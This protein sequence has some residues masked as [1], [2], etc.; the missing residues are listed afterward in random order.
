MI[1]RLIIGILMAGTLAGTLRLP[2]SV[3]AQD[4]AVPGVTIHVVQRGENLFRIALGYGLTTEELAEFNGITNPGNILVGQ[5]LLIPTGA[6]VP[7]P[8]PVQHTV[9]TGETLGSIANLY[10]KTIEELV[11]LNDITNVNAI[12]VGQV[13]TIT[14]GIEANPTQTPLPQPEQLSTPT[15]FVYIVQPGETMYRIALR[16]NLTVNELAS[17]NSITDPT[18]IDAGQHLIIP[19]VTPPQIAPD[20]PS[21]ITEI[22]LS[23]LILVEGQA[24]RIRLTT[25]TA[26]TVSGTLLNNPLPFISEEGN[27][28]HIA[29][30]GIPL[31]TANG[32]Y[33]L[34][35][36]LTQNNGQQTNFSFNVQIV[37]G[38]YGSQNISLPEGSND[39]L[40][41]MSVD[42]FELNLLQNLTS[43]I[44][45]ER[46]FTGP[47]GLP[48]AATMNG[49]F[50]T[51]RSYNGG[52]VNRFHL[53]SDFAGVP[54]TPV[55]AAAP[56][57]VVLAD[58]LSIR[59]IATVIDHGWGVFTGYAHQ[60][61]QYVQF[62]DFVTAGQT[63][64]TIG[65]TG[66]V[67]GPHLHW[68]VWIN[69]VPVDPMQWVQQSFP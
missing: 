47:M 50:G 60:M 8:E 15:S 41:D 38:G 20:L 28:V 46:Y 9:Q 24:G 65:S 25:S 45:P 12:H 61:E 7:E 18:R 32:I 49:P 42:E 36:S 14:P 34:N 62:G 13:L 64:G 37:S 3:I 10:G 67:T 68:E 35:L 26:S 63:I 57:R 56:G 22:N 39:I 27:T 59:G 4:D 33:P 69:G 55:L 51:R 23:P 21:P 54:G 2:A 48:A 30:F 5:R 58:T 29:L 31:T 52:E 66:R 11:G 53:G 44:T 40:L 16:Y 19:G 1:Q 43:N 17:A 6:A